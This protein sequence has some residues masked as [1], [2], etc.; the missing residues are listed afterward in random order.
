MMSQS[1]TTPVVR[2]HYAVR[3]VPDAWVLPEIKVPESRPHDLTND[4]VRDL[5]EAWI[6]REGRDAI[7]TRNLALRWDPEHPRV[8]IDPD[9]CLIEPAPPNETKLM[10]LCLWKPGHRVPPL[11]IE[12]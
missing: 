10:S 7:V 3:P 8:G 2:V 6:K 12:I 5:L 4:R 1:S 9:V 11:A